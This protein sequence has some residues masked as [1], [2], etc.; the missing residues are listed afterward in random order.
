MQKGKEVTCV[1]YGDFGE[2]LELGEEE[3]PAIDMPLDVKT[4]FST[5]EQGRAM[6]EVTLQ[7]STNQKEGRR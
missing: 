4:E 3:T 5:K 6:Q 2:I 7:Q 1:F